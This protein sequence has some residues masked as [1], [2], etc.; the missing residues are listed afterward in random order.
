M[1]PITSI[2]SRA[3]VASRAAGSGAAG[4]FPPDEEAGA[5]TA[6]SP[7]AAIVARSIAATTVSWSQPERS[8]ISAAESPPTMIPWF[9]MTVIAGAGPP[10]RST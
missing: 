1:G 4:P 6:A 10:V 5:P 8:M 7:P 3:R 9:C 2:S